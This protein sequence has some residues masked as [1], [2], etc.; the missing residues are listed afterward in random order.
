MRIF[1]RHHM[2]VCRTD[3]A[4]G[5]FLSYLSR[6]VS[7]TEHP[8]IFTDDDGIK[9]EGIARTWQQWAEELGF[10]LKRFRRVLEKAETLGYIVRARRVWGT[11]RVIRL[12]VAITPAYANEL[13]RCA[14]LGIA[15][16]TAIKRAEP[17]C[18][19][20]TNPEENKGTTELPRRA[21]SNCRPGQL[22]VA[23]CGHFQED[24][25]QTLIQTLQE[26]A[27]ADAV[28]DSEGSDSESEGRESDYSSRRDSSGR[29][30]G[31]DDPQLHDADAEHVGR[32]VISLGG[33]D[34]P[35]TYGLPSLD[36]ITEPQ[37][38]ALRWY[39]DLRGY[40]TTERALIELHLDWESVSGDF[41][42]APNKIDL[43]F[44]AGM[45]ATHRDQQP[46][47]APSD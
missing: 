23:H 46:R 8:A 38:E 40:A 33:V 44:F 19:Q 26:T 30:S 34:D 37:L 5:L 3:V 22:H 45:V 16:Y 29:S 24:S 14:E 20:R 1:Q 21:I 13:K 32:I 11:S 12:H 28:A 35:A 36:S 18:R 27:T 10:T 17:E 9:R 31:K 6:F 39:R 25:S 4:L 41:P 47:N 2:A 7:G 15:K 42:G 43:E